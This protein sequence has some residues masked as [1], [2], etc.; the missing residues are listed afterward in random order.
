MI[1]E[2]PNNFQDIILQQI[3]THKF[4]DP[5]EIFNA[6]EFLRNNGYINGSSIDI[7]AGLV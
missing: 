2:V 3:P 5:N 6:C 4:G 1:S 7:S